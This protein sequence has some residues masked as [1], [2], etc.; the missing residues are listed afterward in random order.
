MSAAGPAVTVIAP[1]L[2]ALEELCPRC[3]VEGL[4]VSPGWDS[5]HAQCNAAQAAWIAQHG[6]LITADGSFYDT[7]AWQT[8]AAAIPAEPESEQCADC[9][10]TG[11]VLT[12]AGRELLRFLRRQLARDLT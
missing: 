1:V 10:S 4:R 11:Y 5:W 2:P 8:L 7:A 9:A 3:R 6:A 12:S